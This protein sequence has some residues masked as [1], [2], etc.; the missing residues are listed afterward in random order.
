MTTGCQTI[1]NGGSPPPSFESEAETLALAKRVGAATSMD[2]FFAASAEKRVD[3]RNRF[4]LGKLMLIDLEY[5][6]YIRALSADR[7]HL[8]SAS[9]LAAM[10]INL[11]TTLVGGVQAKSNLADNR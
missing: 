4:V 8:D 9:A 6:K 10:T 1:R 3:A 7:Q 11:A 5:I 2:D